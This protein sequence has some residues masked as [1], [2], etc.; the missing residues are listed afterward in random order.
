ME[1][2][3]ETNEE[4]MKIQMLEEQQ[5]FMDD[6]REEQME[7]G[8]TPE[9][10]KILDKY[11][12]LNEVKESDNTIKTSY[13]TKA[14]LGKPLFPVRF[15]LEIASYAKL[16]NYDTIRKYCLEKANNITD[17]GLSNEGFLL[18]LV[19]T[20]RRETKTARKSHDVDIQEREKL[21]LKY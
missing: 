1:E 5:D 16:K 21:N 10:E 18:G 11:K 12:F 20:K 4:E 14:E 19:V 15:W 13:V 6:I 9:T 2:E 17:T 7:E 3:F 8:M